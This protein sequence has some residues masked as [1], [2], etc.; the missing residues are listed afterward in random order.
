MCKVC[1]SQ[2]QTEC[3][4]EICLHY[5]AGTLPATFLFPTLL[6]CLDCG[7]TEFKIDEKLP[8]VKRKASLRQSA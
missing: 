5:Q 7:F 1:S 6:V 2:N 4:A 3:K 8:E